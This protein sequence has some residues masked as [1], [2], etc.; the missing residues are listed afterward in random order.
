PRSHLGVAH[1][2]ALA[3]SARRNASAEHG[4]QR[5]PPSQTIVNW[6]LP[7]K[8]SK[9]CAVSGRVRTDRVCVRSTRSRG[10]HPAQGPVPLPVPPLRANAESE[11]DFVASLGHWNT[12][13]ALESRSAYRAR[14]IPRE[15]ADLARTGPLSRRTTAAGN[16]TGTNRSDGYT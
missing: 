6:L 15:A 5:A 14:R 1:A 4:R 16:L 3:L 12:A 13:S 8:L 11:S 9:P 7:L 10:E 2:T